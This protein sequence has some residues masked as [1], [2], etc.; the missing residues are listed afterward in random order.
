MSTD[1]LAV[2]MRSSD[3]RPCFIMPGGLRLPVDPKNS[4]PFTEWAFCYRSAAEA[5]DAVR[6]VRDLYEC[7]P[8]DFVWP[9]FEYLRDLRERLAQAFIVRSLS[10]GAS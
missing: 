2:M 7:T 3:G 10:G 1:R 6:D 4:Q 9:S 5:I 8:P